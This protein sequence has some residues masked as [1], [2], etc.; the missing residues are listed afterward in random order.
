MSFLVVAAACAL[1]ACSN[2][3]LFNHRNAH[4]NPVLSP[5]E[6]SPVVCPLE[7]PK[8]G[9]CASMKWTQGPNED[10]SAFTVSFWRKDQGTVASGPFLAPAPQVKVQLWMPSMGHGSS[11]VK[12]EAPEPGVYNAT[13]VFFIMP[14]DWDVRI[15]LKDGRELLEQVAFRVKI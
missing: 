14:G 3:P 13:D 6:E 9:F 7:F 10:A 11:P 15:Q 1:G 12:V 2:S 8:S 5:A 4:P